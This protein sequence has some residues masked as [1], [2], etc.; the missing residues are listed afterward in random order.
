[1][2]ICAFVTYDMNSLSV[3]NV[4]KCIYTSI[5]LIGKK[6]LF[7]HYS[8]H[9]SISLSFIYSCLHACV[10]VDALQDISP[11]TSI[12]ERFVKVSICAKEN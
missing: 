7:N 2:H 12:C 9:N 3:K 6:K 10:G 11:C 5:W 1:M 4:L 8:L